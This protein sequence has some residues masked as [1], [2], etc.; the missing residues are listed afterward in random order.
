LLLATLQVATAALELRARE[1]LIQY[2][3]SDA[4]PPDRREAADRI[5]IA[6][7]ED[8]E[9]VFYRM[10][11][12]LEARGLVATEDGC[13]LKRIYQEIRIPL[14]HGI[15]GRYSHRRRADADES[16]VESDLASDAVLDALWSQH[17][18][19]SKTTETDMEGIVEEYAAEDLDGVITGLEL[20]TSKFRRSKFFPDVAI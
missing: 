4:V 1:I 3:I 8:R 2:A 10:L 19:Y 15:V 16:A 6:F 17:R 7:E 18:S 13:E 5:E 9:Y 20:L 12:A 14:H 11:S